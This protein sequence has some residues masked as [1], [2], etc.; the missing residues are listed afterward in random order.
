MFSN[1][2]ILLLILDYLKIKILKKNSKKKRIKKWVGKRTRLDII[3]NQIE[4]WIIVLISQA[5]VAH[6]ITVIIIIHLNQN[7]HHLLIIIIIIIIIVDIHIII[8]IHLKY[9]IHNQHQCLVHL[10]Q[11][12][13]VFVIV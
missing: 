4:I 10:N 9:V 1:Q 11:I 8:D 12:I 3:I 13:M 7:Q 2:S 5:H 6:L